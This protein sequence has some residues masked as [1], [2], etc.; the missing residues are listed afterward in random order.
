M[1]AIISLAPPWEERVKGGGLQVVI[2]KAVTAVS[3]LMALKNF[4]GSDHLTDQ[5]RVKTRDVNPGDSGVTQ[6]S[7]A[8]LPPMQSTPGDR[9]RWAGAG[10]PPTTQDTFAPY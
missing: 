2:S 7:G 9:G 8:C 10:S 4:V 5:S 6:R 3:H 1:R